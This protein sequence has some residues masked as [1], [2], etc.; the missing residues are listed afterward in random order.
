RTVR[1]AAALLREEGVL[2]VG[3]NRRGREV[4]GALRLPVPD[5]DAY[6]SVRLTRRRPHHAGPSLL[7]G[8]V[9]WVVAGPDDPLEPLPRDLP[10]PRRPR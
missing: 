4:A 6:V 7:A 1:E 10:N 8:G 3:G 5:A 9:A 2:V